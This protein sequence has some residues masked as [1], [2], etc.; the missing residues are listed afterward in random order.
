ME[1]MVKNEKISVTD[2]TF[3]FK[4][5]YDVKSKEDLLALIKK[6]HETGQ[7]GMHVKDLKDTWKNLFKGIDELEKLCQIFV[8]RHRDKPV[9]LL[10]NNLLPEFFKVRRY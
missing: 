1:L 9:V 3:A 10:Y 2:T 6:H 8:I 4:P 5:T 7:G